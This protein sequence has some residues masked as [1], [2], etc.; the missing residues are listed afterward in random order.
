MNYDKKT[1]SQYP[2]I[3]V[4]TSD[5]VIFLNETEILYCKAEGSYT[6]IYLQGAIKNKIT[7]SKSLSRVLESLHNEYFVRIHNSFVINLLHLTSFS[8]TDKNCVVMSE[9]E[10]LTISRARKKSLMKRFRII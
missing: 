2:G 1:I 9:G 8:K 10:N 3:V 5:G 6:H 7:V 4:N